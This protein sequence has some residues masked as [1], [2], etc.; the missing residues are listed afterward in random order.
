M[1]F[2]FVNTRRL[3]GVRTRRF[4]VVLMYLGLVTGEMML[5]LHAAHV[6]GIHATPFLWL[7]MGAIGALVVGYFGLIL[8]PWVLA[9]EMKRRNLDERLGQRRKESYAKA[10]RLFTV[11]FCVEGMAWILRDFFATDPTIF[12]NADML[13]PVIM[14]DV[15][16][17]ATLPMAIYAWTEPNPL[18]DESEQQP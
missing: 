13:H 2:S 3:E 5:V 8:I 9:I 4:L 6:P 14:L 7:A 11:V 1:R 18:H 12:R 15:M 17:L 16:L 10:Y